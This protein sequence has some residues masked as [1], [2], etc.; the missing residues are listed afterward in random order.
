[1]HCTV[2]IFACNFVAETDDQGSSHSASVELKT[3]LDQQYY[4]SLDGFLIVIARNGDIVYVS[5]NIEKY[6]GLTQVCLDA[7]CAHFCIVISFCINVCCGQ[8]VVTRDV[9]REPENREPVWKVR[10]R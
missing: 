9:K 2:Y 3:K 7:L 4:K 5:E 8:T 6:L 10:N 1:M